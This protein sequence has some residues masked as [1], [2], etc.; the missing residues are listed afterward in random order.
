EQMRF[1]EKLRYSIDVDDDVIPEDWEIP[2]MIIQPYLENALLHGI[3]PARTAGEL[4]VRISRQEER[5][6]VSICYNGIG[7]ANSMQLKRQN[8]HIS[9]SMEL[10]RKRIAI[11]QK[12]HG[13][14]VSIEVAPCHDDA[15]HPGTRVSMT[16][17]G[18]FVGS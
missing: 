7:I 10:I 18:H 16:F 5:L 3:T 15:V 13:Q 17:R 6:Q 2:A 4:R 14:S 12:L 9:R 8:G 11:L 1:G